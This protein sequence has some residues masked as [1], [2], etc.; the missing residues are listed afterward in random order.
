MPAPGA[1]L[2]Q[3]DSSLGC[4]WGSLPVVD[5]NLWPSVPILVGNATLIVSE[6]VYL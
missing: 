3:L 6:H 1:Q 5:N 4:W 2:S